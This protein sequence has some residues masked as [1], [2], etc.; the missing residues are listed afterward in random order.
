MDTK[1]KLKLDAT[2][3][4]NFCN[5]IEKSN[6]TQYEE[7]TSYYYLRD[8]YFC[9]SLD[10]ARIK[11]E[12]EILK[13]LSSNIGAKNTNLSNAVNHFA[14][15]CLSQFANQSS[16]LEF[17]EA[18]RENGFNFTES[19]HSPNKSKKLNPDIPIP[20]ALQVV[21]PQKSSNDELRKY[22]NSLIMDIVFNNEQLERN[23]R[24]INE[25]AKKTKQQ[26][27]TLIGEIQDFL[28]LYNTAIAGKKISKT[29]E[30]ALSRQADRALVT[31][32][33]LNKLIHR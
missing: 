32:D 12:V 26:G 30:M 7:H 23:I 13:K 22:I 10:I 1:L 2:D 25:I 27:N 19:E 33:T 21:D 24:Y 14:E 17:K 18:L 6:I 4:L 5:I 31:K 29:M 3:W 16:F 15:L 9:S 8:M 11:K 28:E 20:E